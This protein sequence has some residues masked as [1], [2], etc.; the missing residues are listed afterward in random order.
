MILRPAAETEYK[1]IIVMFYGLI[2][3]ILFP[4]I[5]R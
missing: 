3:L 5:A 4:Y 2:V 1:C